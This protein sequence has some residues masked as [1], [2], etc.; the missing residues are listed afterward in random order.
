MALLIVTLPRNLDGSDALFFARD[1]SRRGADL[2]ELRT[3]WHAALEVDFVKLRRSIELLVSERGTPIPPHWIEHAQLVELPLGGA[4]LGGAGPTASLVAHRSDRPLTPAEA[5]ALW[6]SSGLPKKTRVLHVEPLGDVAAGMRLFETQRELGKLFS[7]VSVIAEGELALPFRCALSERNHL[8]LVTIDRT[9]RAPDGARRL[10]DAARQKESSV[11]H[12]RL[13]LLGTDVQD[14]YAP[15][16]HRPPFDRID[17]PPDAPVGEL[18]DALRKHYS[19]FAITHPFKT[20]VADH[21]GVADDAV[22]TLIR[23]RRGWRAENTDPE[24]A[25]V[26]LKRLRSKAVTVLGSGGAARSMIQIADALGIAL[27][28]VRRAEITPAPID[29]PCVWTWPEDVEIPR[30]L[31][32]APGTPVAVIAWGDPGKR[33][34]EEIRARGGEP[35]LMGSAWFMAKT[36]RQRE[37]WEEP[38]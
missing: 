7:G 18:I 36:R 32:F 15:E 2:L 33:L 26:V 3:D 19:G 17:L 38:K 20:I 9:R 5:A 27:R 6:K 37:L 30:A 14:S 22:N 11:R 34:A 8:D 4:S 10:D 24:G 12:D 28:I 16:V 1:A 35:K 21:L 13:G 25:R 23:T 31:T 29:G